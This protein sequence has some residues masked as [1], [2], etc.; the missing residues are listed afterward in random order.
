M[1]AL[2][3]VNKK[4]KGL[5]EIIKVNDSYVIIWNKYEEDGE[6]SEEIEAIGQDIVNEK[7][8]ILN[9]EITAWGQIKTDMEACDEL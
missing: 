1:N 4:A 7:I 8:S 3:Y 5:A 9:D 6:I 2:D